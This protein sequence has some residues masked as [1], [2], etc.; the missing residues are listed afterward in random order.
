MLH[1]SYGSCLH[2]L[3][4]TWQAG[5]GVG[6]PIAPAQRPQDVERDTSRRRPAIVE[7]QA[8][9]FGQCSLVIN[10]ALAESNPKSATSALV[11]VLKQSAATAVRCAPAHPSTCP[12]S[13][14]QLRV[15]LPQV[16]FK[17]LLQ[18]GQKRGASQGYVAAANALSCLLIPP[19]VNLPCPHLC[20]VHVKRPHQAPLVLRVGH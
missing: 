3:L 18:S 1:T 15:V 10:E 4:Y 17:H 9:R 8:V 7:W 16:V 5:Q 11:L 14:Q 19:A 20:A 12:P 6:W 13:P 2:V